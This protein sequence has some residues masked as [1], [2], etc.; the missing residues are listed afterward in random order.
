MK[1]FVLTIVA[2][3]AVTIISCNKENDFSSNLTITLAEQL[4]NDL[5]SIPKAQPNPKLEAEVREF[6]LTANLDYI[7]SGIKHR[8]PISYPLIDFKNNS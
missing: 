3:F 2:L 1:N 7:K 6:K 4:K 8:V 5:Y